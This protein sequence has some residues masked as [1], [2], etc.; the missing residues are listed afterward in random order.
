MIGGYV[1]D[2]VLRNTFRLDQYLNYDEMAPMRMQRFSVPICLLM[3]SY[4]MAAGG[5]IGS[6]QKYKYTTAVELFDIGAN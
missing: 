2:M 3:N 4:I 1:N 6:P 5:S